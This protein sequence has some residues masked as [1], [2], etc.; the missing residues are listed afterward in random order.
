M[1]PASL[2]DIKKEIAHLDHGELAAL[3]L[4]IA[5]YKKE[6]KELLSY[7][8]FELSDENNFI[9]GV[10]SETDLLFE[11]INYSNLYYAKKG[12]RKALRHV[13]KNIRYSGIAAT[14]AELLIYFCQKLKATGIHLEKSVSLNN[15][16]L[17]QLKKIN[18]TIEGMHE[19]LQF[20]FKKE[21]KAL[22]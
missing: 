17:A 12:I 3:C 9:L 7:L 8:L 22:E 16:Y 18:K 11:E 5:K 2:S 21:L 19:D 15:I 13:N 4:R 1:K 14:Q 20:D 10:K 6:N